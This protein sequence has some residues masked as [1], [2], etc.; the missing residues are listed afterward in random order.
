MFRRSHLTALPRPAGIKCP[1]CMFSTR[2]NLPQVTQR[3]QPFLSAADQRIICESNVHAC[4]LRARLREALR[5][6]RRARVIQPSLA[7]Q[8][9]LSGAPALSRLARYPPL[10][11]SC[12]QELLLLGRLLKIETGLF[13]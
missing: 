1:A 12:D 11:L 3:T 13:P 5:F 6:L 2:S 7:I 4:A 9:P 8:P 10:R